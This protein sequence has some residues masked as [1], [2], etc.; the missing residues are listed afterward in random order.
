MNKTQY[1]E[2]FTVSKELAELHYE[3]FQKLKRA[4]D[5]T[6]FLLINDPT[7]QNMEIDCPADDCADSL[8]RQTLLH[9]ADTFLLGAS[10]MLG[11]AYGYI[12]EQEGRM[13]QDVKPEKDA[14]YSPS[15]KGSKAQLNFHNDITFTLPESFYVSNPDYTCLYCV[16]APAEPV[17]T[18]V[19]T[20]EK[21]LELLTEEEVRIAKTPIFH[22]SSPYGYNEVYNNGESIWIKEKPILSG[23]DSPEIFLTASGVKTDVPEGQALIRKLSEVVFDTANAQ[24]VNLE[25]GQALLID[26]RRAL[27]ARSAFD[28]EFDGNDRWLR[29]VY[30]KG[31]NSLMQADIINGFVKRQSD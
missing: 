22:F 5:E 10:Y 24:A 11:E 2:S 1:I 20:V 18:Y 31:T 28:P 23:T 21:I 17:Y 6:R 14:A 30:V 19:I 12:T 26:N 3:N 8:E 25:K 4:E 9:R 15:Y 27:H 7:F 29:R 13:V 16:R